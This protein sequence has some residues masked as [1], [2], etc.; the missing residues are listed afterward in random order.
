MASKHTALRLQVPISIAGVGAIF[1][2]I[3]T[4]SI[5]GGNLTTALI[6]ATNVD[7]VPTIAAM[8]I[9][10]AP[11]VI[12]PLVVYIVSRIHLLE[13]DRSE[14]IRTLFIVA[15]G[16]ALLIAL[17]VSSIATLITC[18]LV[19]L[20][21]GLHVFSHKNNWKL[22]FAKTLTPNTFYQ[23]ISALFVASLVITPS[24]LARETAIIDGKPAVISVI[25]ETDEL[26]Y[27]LDAASAK[28]VYAKPE[29]LNERA[30]CGSGDVETLASLIGKMIGGQTYPSCP[31]DKA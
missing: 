6:V 14:E 3:S 23:L 12:F 22:K 24:W 15:V 19:Y 18:L 30:F 17:C 10:V 7:F 1:Y 8:L 16:L 27:Y 4:F 5:A 26:L 28:V 31:K 13:Y 29:D 25:K 9:R 21:H 20:L 2:G 11:Y